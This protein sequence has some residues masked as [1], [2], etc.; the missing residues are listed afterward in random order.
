MRAKTIQTKEADMALKFVTSDA[1]QS[2]RKTVG[3]S[4]ESL[5]ES[6]EEVASAAEALMEAQADGAEI[7]QV[8]DNLTIACESLKNGGLTANLIGVFN[9][10]GELSA[11]AGQEN[12][13]IAGLEALAE[14]QVKTLSAK[15]V[16]GV[17]GRMTEYWAKFIAYLKNL[18]AKIVNWFKSIL[19]NRARY[20]K[21]LTEGGDVNDEQFKKAASTKF[22]SIGPKGVNP[23]MDPA[24]TDLV[25]EISKCAS[26]VKSK[27]ASNL[28]D[29]PGFDVKVI[30]AFEEKFKISEETTLSDYFV[31]AQRFNDVVSSYRKSAGSQKF[32]V[33]SK[34]VDTAFKTL[35]TDAGNAA[36]IT[37]EEKKT[38]TKNAIN[39]R[40]NTI[41]TLLRAC[42][43]EARHC[44]KVGGTLLRLK[45][46]ILAA[47]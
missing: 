28:A 46:T 45:K 7:C 6:I 18:W 20:V 29:D 12:L 24:Y 33:A 31:N 1:V 14:N 5:V 16:A 19:T 2:L 32:L 41:N 13:T 17:E 43:V 47:K 10:E 25:D 34:D 42:R 8:L 11:C 35:V 23:M 37:D 4:E 22:K 40:R 26:A 27:S 44:M 9:S 30:S 21:A 38:A 36:G 39:T 3:V 15:Y